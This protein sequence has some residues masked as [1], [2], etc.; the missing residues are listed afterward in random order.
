MSLHVPRQA[1]PT[2]PYVRRTPPGVWHPDEYRRLADFDHDAPDPRY[3]ASG[4]EAMRAGL[5]GVEAPPAAARKAIDR[6]ARRGAGRF[7][8]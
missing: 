7:D 6:L 3:Y 5:A 4:A 2:C 1:C 8:A